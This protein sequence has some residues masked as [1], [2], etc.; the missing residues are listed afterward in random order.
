MCVDCKAL[1]KI[2]VKNK[3]SVPLIQD[4]FDRLS[5]ATYFTKLDLRSG[6]WQVRIA[7]GDE[8][9][10]TCVTQYGSFEFL[11]MPKG[12]TNALATF[13]NLMNDIFYDYIDRFIVAYLDDIVVYSESFVDHLCHLRQVLSRLKKN[14]L[15]VKKEKCKFACKDILF[16]GQRISLGKIMMDEGKVKTIRDW[17]PPKSV[18]EL[19]SFLGLDNYYWKFI[20]AYAK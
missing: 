9:K 4:L 13:Y 12:I 20:V 15:F 2:T 17:P 16:L 14:S 19:R 11:V 3:Y 7:E 18:P 6:Y 8:P 10:T 1:N 5:I